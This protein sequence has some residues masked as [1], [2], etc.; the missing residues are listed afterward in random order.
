MQVII[1]ILIVI[2]AAVTLAGQIK[3]TAAAQKTRLQK[4]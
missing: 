3:I 4:L 1:V 2:E